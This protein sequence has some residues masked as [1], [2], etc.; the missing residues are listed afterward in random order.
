MSTEKHAIPNG[1]LRCGKLSGIINDISHL[2]FFYH[3]FHGGMC[4][5]TWQRA[6]MINR[7][8]GVC[9]TGV[10]CCFSE[11]NKTSASTYESP[12]S[13][14]SS[15]FANHIITDVSIAQILFACELHSFSSWLSHNLF[16]LPEAQGLHGTKINLSYP[17]SVFTTVITVSHWA[18]T[19][20]TNSLE[21]KEM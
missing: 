18:F 5:E 13:S 8:H 21:R 6:A 1:N 19:W 17:E 20:R 14:R 15:G 4:G 10:L 16:N 9:G 2:S 3:H 7:A 11:N 12:Q